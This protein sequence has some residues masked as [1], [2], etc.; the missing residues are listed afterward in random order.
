MHPVTKSILDYNAGRDPERLRI[1]LLAINSDPF[2]FFRGTAPLF[3]AGLKMP[4]HLLQA[5]QVLA[6]GD[7]H[8][9]NIGSYK[10]DNR[11]V[12]FDLNDFDEAC[13]APLT[14][15]LVRFLSSTIVAAAMLKVSRKQAIRLT[16][17]FVDAY[18]A[19]LLTTK[20]RW[21]ERG[22][23]TGPIKKLLQRLKSR[24]R[25]ELIARRTVERKG[26]TKL[27]IDG[28]RSM[29]VTDADRAKAESILASYASTQASPS[30]F[31][32]ID[33]ARRIAG[34][35]SLGLERYVALV[36]G[37][38][39]RDG[40]YL[41]DIKMA[42]PSALAVHLKQKQ[43][44]WVSEAQRIVTL[45]GIAQAIAPALLGAVH[46]GKNSYVIKELQP[47]ADRINLPA[48][49]GKRQDLESVLS[50]IAEITAWAHLRGASRFGVDSIETLASFAAD[51]TWK[52]TIKDLAESS[53]TLNQQQWQAYAVDCNSG[54]VGGAQDNKRT[55]KR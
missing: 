17:T 5:P 18:A 1:K 29:T 20:P 4:R 40:R 2:A 28:I 24:H 9:E 32:P 30:H 22:T 16:A 41:V 51:E 49:N 35:G 36:R 45:Q 53:A 15:E 11:M 38:G 21:I 26:A 50:T 42:N 37:D 33:I 6:C 25:P 10:G 55:T 27:L 13:M 14:F 48:L 54:K 7:L 12:Y 19:T 3:Y 31:Q 47:T 44:R 39:T 43:P 23:A 46:T 52:T 34:N 8:L